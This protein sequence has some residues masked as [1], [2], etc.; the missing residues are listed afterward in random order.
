MGINILFSFSTQ[1]A[2]LL[3][4]FKNILASSQNFNSH[5]TT[6]IIS[7]LSMTY[8]YCELKCH[9]ANEN[10]S[11]SDFLTTYKHGW[12]LANKIIFCLAGLI[13]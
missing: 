8:N 12:N 9:Q 4:L 3:S 6:L 5:K 13:R 10:I 2:D 1:N 7:T 11:S